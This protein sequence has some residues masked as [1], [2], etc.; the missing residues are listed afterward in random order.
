MRERRNKDARTRW[1]P[2]AGTALCVAAVAG[3]GW[4]AHQALLG[5]SSFH[6]SEVRIQG[7]A[8][9]AAAEIISRLGLR[10]PV[11]IL[12]MN[13]EELAGRLTTHPWISSA[14]IQRHFPSRLIITVEEREPV[15]LL[16]A[17]KTFLLS[18]DA[19]ILD[20][21]RGA[22]TRTLP[23]LQPRWRAEYRVG[24]RVDDPRLVGGLDLLG[25]LRKAPL[26]HG[27]QVERVTAEADGNYILRL[28]EG[29]ALLRVSPAE[30]L[31][32]LHR[33]EIALR[34]RGKGLQSFAYVD[35]RFPGRVIVKP[36]EK[37]G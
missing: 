7:N 32:Q 10:A 24:A 8:H 26:L 21:V 37:G 22:P 16:S 34:H 2:I 18:A 20:E 30:P 19:V 36:P 15:A 3:G 23:T 35:L 5:F 28:A 25:T 27:R 11:N 9:V 6:V 12:Q 31:V 17:G 13:M 29:G 4:W 14:S 1:W 33:L